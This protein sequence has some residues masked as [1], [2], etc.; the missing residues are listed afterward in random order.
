M[1]TPWANP[2]LREFLKQDEHL[3]P[4]GFVT[5]I[6]KICYMDRKRPITTIKQLRNKRIGA[7]PSIGLQTVLHLE[8]L[9][10]RYAGRAPPTGRGPTMTAMGLTF[11]ALRQ[12]DEQRQKEWDPDNAITLEFRG[13]ELAGEVGEACNVI[14]KLA[15]ERLG[16]RGNR[17][18]KQQLAEELADIIICADLIGMQAGI[19]LASAVR[20]KFDA[21]SA[22]YRLKTRLGGNSK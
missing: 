3:A 22:K 11:A 10:N 5:R 1:R 17:A 15:R 16:L 18:T 2:E 12:A 21:T 14:K 8:Y 19:D 13:N 7:M 20:E 4:K 9:L 6:L